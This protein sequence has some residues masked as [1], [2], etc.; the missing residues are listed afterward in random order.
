MC[1]SSEVAYCGLFCGD[2]VIRNRK[3]GALSRELLDCIRTPEF[4]KLVEGMPKLE[5]EL[6]DALK[7]YQTCCRVLEAMMHLDCH[8][9]CKDGGGKAIDYHES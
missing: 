5:P 1:N 6:Y 4:H 2:C 7:H 8:S 9:I 3:P